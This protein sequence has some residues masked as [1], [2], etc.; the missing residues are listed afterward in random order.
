[1]GER[2]RM[3]VSGRTEGLV[4]EIA[5]L[6]LVLLLLLVMVRSTTLG[7]GVCGSPGGGG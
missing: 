7:H 3:K 2:V 5:P 4:F 1:M 6:V